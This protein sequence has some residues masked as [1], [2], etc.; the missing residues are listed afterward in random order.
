MDQPQKGPNSL[1]GVPAPKGRISVA[2][3]VDYHMILDNE[4]SQLSRPETG[5]VGSFG[6]AG[7]G[8]ALGLAP[9]FYE[10]WSKLPKDGQ[11]VMFKQGEI[12]TVSL[13]VGSFVICIV[14][15]IIFGINVFRNRGL[16]KLIRNRQRN[17][18]ADTQTPHE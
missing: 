3:F 17:S 2:E 13:F 6:F 1:V 4:L 11:P 5:I 16:A 14:C 7:F 18:M 9:A 12:I 8:G 15:L 10:A